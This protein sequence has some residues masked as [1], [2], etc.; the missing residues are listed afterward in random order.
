MR[1]PRTIQIV[2]VNHRSLDAYQ[3]VCG[4]ELSVK[5][6]LTCT[7]SQAYLFKYDSTHGTYQGDVRVDTDGY[8]VVDGNR[9]RVHAMLVESHWI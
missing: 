8:L 4:T 6:T 2:A 5:S 9:S 7:C 3:M 1:T